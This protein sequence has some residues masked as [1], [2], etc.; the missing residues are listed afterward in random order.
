MFQQ[1]YSRDKSPQ[2]QLHKA[3]APERIRVRSKRDKFHDA[4]ARNPPRFL[5]CPSTYRVIPRRKE[6]QTVKEKREM[7]QNTWEPVPKV[8][9]NSIIPRIRKNAPPQDKRRVV[10]RIGRVRC[11]LRDIFSHN[12]ESYSPSIPQ[13]LILKSFWF[14][15]VR[16]GRTNRSSFDHALIFVFLVFE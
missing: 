15:V 5:G 9:L 16:A 11:N 7:Y 8:Y 6:N 3:G 12:P 2:Y 1:I 4:L 14:R 13:E 10:E